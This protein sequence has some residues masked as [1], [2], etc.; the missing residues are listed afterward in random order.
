MP[1]LTISTA[2]EKAQVITFLR[3]RKYPDNLDSKQRT[4]FARKYANL[5]LHDKELHYKRP[6]DR[7]LLRFYC[8]HEREMKLERIKQIHIGLSHFKRDKMLKELKHVIFCTRREE[9]EFVL[10]RCR[11]CALITKILPK[12]TSR[13]V[14][15][16]A[17]RERYQAGLVDLSEYADVNDGYG[18]ILSIMDVYSRFLMSVP[19]KSKSAE[20]VKEGFEKLFSVLGESVTLQTSNIS[21]FWDALFTEYLDSLNV[22]LV[23]GSTELP[24]TNRQIRRYNSALKLLRRKEEASGQLKNRWIDTH[25]E[26]VSIYNR[27]AHNAHDQLPIRIF[28]RREAGES[29]SQRAMD[30]LKIDELVEEIVEGEVI[31]YEVGFF[32]DPISDP[33][34][35][36]IDVEHDSLPS[37]L[38]PEDELAS[39]DPAMHALDGE[40]DEEAYKDTKVHEGGAN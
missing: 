10:K 40:T 20:E 38:G 17:P 12:P 3:K 9:V 7:T 15:A 5:I 11:Q 19:L 23:Y 29:L 32:E 26:A 39:K 24:E 37:G 16:S 34:L 35:E 2:A 28:F 4:A 13:I 31:V 6:K 33:E 22:K 36:Y 1:S 18:W 30:F 14:T 25:R 8:E 21:E 27:S